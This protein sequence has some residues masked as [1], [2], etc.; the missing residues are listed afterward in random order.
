MDEA[1]LLGDAAGSVSGEVVAQGLRL[2]DAGVPIA[3]DI[4][5][6]PV[7][8]L[9]DPAVPSRVCHRRYSSQASSSQAIPVSVILDEIVLSVESGLG[10]GDLPRGPRPVPGA[11][12]GPGGATPSR[13]VSS[14]S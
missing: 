5:E 10:T 14:A 9:E 12:G 2:A 3:L 7:D 4:A 11:F 8:A 1:V 6:D 13:S